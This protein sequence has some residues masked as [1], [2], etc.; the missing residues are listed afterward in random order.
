MMI[1][2]DDLKVIAD[3]SENLSRID[4][5]KLSFKEFKKVAFHI[6]LMNERLQDLNKNLENKVQ[7]R[8]MELEKSERYSR[9]LVKQQD[10]FVKDAI[11]EI[12]TPLSIIIANI[13][14][15]KL[16]SGENKYLSK[17]E[18]GAKIIHNIYN[19]L[20]YMIKKDR[21]EYKPSRMDISAFI[22]ERL[23]FFNEIAVGNSLRFESYIEKG[24]FIDFNEIYLQRI[25][26]N[27]LSNAIKYSYRDS[28]VNVKLYKKNSKIL[29][30]II[31]NGET[32][33][34]PDKLFDRFY[35]ENEIRGGFGI[36][37]SIIKEIC[38]KNGVFA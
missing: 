27:T 37:L 15:F 4:M 9:N 17:I 38:D 34:N 28:V 11:H 31:N 12:N 20:E 8:T 21:I 26:D 10:K 14:L 23:E 19:D 30:E 32:I 16:K 1:I 18:A 24:H 35:R 7:I 33:K 3:C 5:D 2:Q 6:N 22:N 29:L 25:C 36:G 13:D